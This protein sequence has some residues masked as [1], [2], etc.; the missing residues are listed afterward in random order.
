[1]RGQSDT[2]PPQY[3]TTEFSNGV[4]EIILYD[5]ITEGTAFDEEQNEKTVY[6]FVMYEIKVPTREGIQNTVGTNYDE[7]LSYAKGQNDKPKSDKEKIE[8]LDLILSEL[9]FDIIPAM[10]GGN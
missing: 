1:M 9:L 2:R 5:E 10:L 8:E 3:E 7:W 4:T 6:E